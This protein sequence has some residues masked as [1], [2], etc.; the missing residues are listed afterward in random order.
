MRYIRTASCR[1]SWVEPSRPPKD[2]LLAYAGARHSWVYLEARRLQRLRV[3]SDGMQ[4]ETVIGQVAVYSV[5]EIRRA[6]RL[7]HGH[8]AFGTLM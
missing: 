3:A 1:P 7:V 6:G 8:E 2:Q 5:T 4:Q